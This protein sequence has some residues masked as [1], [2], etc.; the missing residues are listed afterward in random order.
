M[1]SISE[2]YIYPI[3]SL[4]GIS[5]KESVV[6]RWGLHHDRRWM[7]VDENKRFIT[8]RENSGLALL[9]VGISELGLEVTHKVNKST[10]KISF[11]PQTEEEAEVTFFQKLV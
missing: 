11:E 9:Q 8:Q 1:Y 7:L 4:G 3:K 10:I 5:L 6:T 2:L